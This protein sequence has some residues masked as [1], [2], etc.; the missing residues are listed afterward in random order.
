MSADTVPMISAF[1]LAFFL[2]FFGGY[3]LGTIPFG[4]LLSRLAGV[5]D[6][7]DIGS[8]N[9]GATNV[10]RTGKKSLAAATLLLDGG[11]GAAAV[12]LACLAGETADLPLQTA[13]ILGLVAGSGALMGHIFP[14]WLNFKGGKGVATA[15][16]IILAVNV[17][18][19]LLTCLTW[20]GAAL[21]SRHSSV[22]ALVA[23]ATS[24]LYALL[25][26]DAGEPTLALMVFMAVLVI[27][28]HRVNIRRLLTGNE[29]K[30]GNT[31]DK[32]DDP[33]G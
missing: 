10:L 28:R 11:K 21:V 20:L 19:G 27:L 5:G 25:V 29:D 8:G 3:L 4:L 7:R 31:T 13:Q 26:F 33:P 30:I 9:I 23:M 6:I 1:P 16:G 14:L 22:G 15:L 18:L 12:L 2:A 24:P 17:L 32:L